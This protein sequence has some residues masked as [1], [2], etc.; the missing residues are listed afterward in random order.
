MGDDG[1]DD[2]M[3]AVLAIAG[4]LDLPAVLD[5]LVHAAAALTGAGC[6]AINVLD[7]HRSL[8][9]VQTGVD[10]ATASA[11]G[12][13]PSACGVLGQIPAVGAIRLD[14][15]GAHPAFGG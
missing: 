2:L 8:A 14:D 3:D 4:E 13:A 11:I 12:H 7:D 6:A 5:R 15:V 1:L 9:F 10:P